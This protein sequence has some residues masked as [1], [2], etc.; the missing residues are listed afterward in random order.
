MLTRPSPAKLNL[1][2]RVTGTRP[3]GFHTL[4]S[5][6][7]QTPLTDT[8]H[9]AA[10][11]DE[12]LTLTCDRAD[13]PADA[14]NLAWRAAEALRK[15]AGI[16][17]GADIALTK[18]IPA[19][20]GLGGGSSNAATTLQL[21]NEVWQ[22]GWPAD[23]LA[24]VGA[25][26]GS[27]VPVFLHGPLSIMRGRGEIVEPLRQPYDFWAAVVLPRLHCATPAVYAAWDRLTEHPTRPEL[28]AVLAQLASPPALMAVL[29]NDLEEAAF[30]VNPSLRE[31]AARATN[32]AGQPVR[33][34]GSGAA[35]FSL[36]A[37]QFAAERC[38]A[39]IARDVQVPVEV[40]HVTRI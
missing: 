36:F 31:L 11:D 40:L 37:E 4:E 21:L 28:S 27:D 32:A 2:L 16:S 1:T 34:T 22:L 6:V 14:S 23:R 17:L 26:V 10:R 15:A 12:R 18:R 30:A 8:V 38:A 9:V 35:L 25:Q 20:A 3:D 19:G 7:V 33:L 5:L 29:F 13:I 39:A 24:E